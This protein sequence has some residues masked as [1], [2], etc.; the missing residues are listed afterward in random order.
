MTA[1]GTNRG[2]YGR[3]DRPKSQ[4]HGYLLF[5]AYIVLAGV[6]VLLMKRG[7]AVGARPC[8]TDA[9][10][11]T[12][13]TGLH[14]TSQV[15]RSLHLSGETATQAGEANCDYR[16]AARPHESVPCPVH[17]DARAGW[18]PGAMLDFRPA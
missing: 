14:Q 18:R 4:S 13:L 7:R 16:V 17:G 3:I 5:I 10:G 12:G 11:D 8:S 1:G 6:S 9:G 2:G 15:S